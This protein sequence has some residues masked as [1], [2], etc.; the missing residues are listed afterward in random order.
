MKFV[1]STV[2]EMKNSIDGFNIK[3]D[4]VGNIVYKLECIQI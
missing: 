3:L 2:T 4:R 1:K